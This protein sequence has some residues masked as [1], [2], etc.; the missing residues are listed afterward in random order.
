MGKINLLKLEDTSPFRKIAMGSW[1]TVKDP[2][3]YGEVEIDV[4]DVLPKMREFSSKHGIKITPLHLVAKAVTY[5]IKQRPEINALIRGSRIY[6][7]KN[8]SLFFQVNIPGSDKFDKVKKAT[9]SGAVIHEAED[10]SLLEIVKKLHEKAASIKSN[11]DKELSKNIAIFKFLPW[12]LSSAYLNLASFLLYGLNLDLSFL[13]FPK[14]PFGSIMITNVGGLG[15]DKAWAPLVPYTRV[16]LV[17]TLGAIK[18]KPWVLND[19]ILAREI[20][21]VCFTFDHRLIDG[22]HASQLSQQFKECFQN[23]E[24]YFFQE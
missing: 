18:K 8:L 24:K 5:C 10:L 11:Q 20:L 13:G 14:D 12:W 6:L 22:V 3:V 16:P 17:I 2:S 1:K 15:I 9:L 7:R 19:E 23:S 21:T 4:T